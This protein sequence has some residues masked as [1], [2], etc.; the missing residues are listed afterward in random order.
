MSRSTR[1][2]V[3]DFGAEMYHDPDG[4]V[5]PHAWETICGIAIQTAGTRQVIEEHG[6][7][8]ELDVADATVPCPKCYGRR[9]AS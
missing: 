8:V 5:Y 4:P 9:K 3:R 1:V 7:L 2:W 6:V